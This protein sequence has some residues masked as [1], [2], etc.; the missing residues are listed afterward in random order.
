[1][2]SLGADEVI[3]YRTTDYTRP[4]QPYDWILDVD[5]HAPVRDFR[6]ALRTGGVYAA[7][8]GSGRW[9]L[10]LLFWQPIMK[11]TT[12]KTMGMMLHWKPFNPPDL[13]ELT[14]LIASGELRPAIDRRFT[15]DEVADALSYVHTGQSRG[16]VLVI[17]SPAT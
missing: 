7:A 8:G 9:F 12:D 4:A 2:R 17:P 15:L 3:D 6:R 5:A 14:R 10:A 1:M 11:L 16:K 13:E